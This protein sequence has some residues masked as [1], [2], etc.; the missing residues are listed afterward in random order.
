VGDRCL[1]VSQGCRNSEVILYGSM[2][3]GWSYCRLALFIT[4]NVVFW[5]CFGMLMYRFGR[6]NGL[7][8]A[9]KIWDKTLKEY[10][11]EKPKDEKS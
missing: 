11:K 9:K 2:F 6:N 1:G 4:G 8:A 5:V 7:D 10:Q 3:Q